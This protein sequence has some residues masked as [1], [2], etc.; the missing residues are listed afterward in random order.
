MKIPSSG[1]VENNLMSYCGL[2]DTRISAYEKY[3]PTYG[4]HLEN[5]F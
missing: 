2:V 4:F 1:R 5:D 3:L